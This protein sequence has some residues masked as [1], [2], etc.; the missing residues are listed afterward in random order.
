MYPYLDCSATF[1]IEKCL[2]TL[3]FMDYKRSSWLETKR[4]MVQALS[5]P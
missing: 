5:L 4:L 3:L 1:D 2:I